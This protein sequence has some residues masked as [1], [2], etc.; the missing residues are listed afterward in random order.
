MGAAHR[1]DTLNGVASKAIETP[2]R[3]AGGAP[4]PRPVRR[5]VWHSARYRIA[6]RSLGKLLARTIGAPLVARRARSWKYEELHPERKLEAQAAGG[7]ILAMWHGRMLCPIPLYKGQDFTVLVSASDDGDLS[8]A[9][10]R[11]FGYRV[12]RGSA[13]RGGASA[14][15]GLLNA[16]RRGSTVAV[17]PDGPRGPR[18]SM[19]LGPA[20]IARATGHPILPAGFA[21]SPKRELGSW[22]RYN[23]PC[24]GA[25]VVA[26]YGEPIH[27]ARHADRAE[28][29]LVSARLR[30]ALIEAERAAFARLGEEPDF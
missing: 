21:C 6:R 1:A 14:L 24:R 10:L 13:S 29:E 9:L 26:S 8:E 7:V 20:W 5:G 15:R 25:R 19:N 18:H 2:P 16:L 28:L 22:D 4:E 27:V 11:G 30:E 23:I 12:V 17:T 3:A